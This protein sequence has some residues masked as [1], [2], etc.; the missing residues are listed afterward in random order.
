MSECTGCIY[1][2]LDY[3][4]SEEPCCN[5]RRIATDYYDYYDGIDL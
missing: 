2:K 5:C 4:V 1:D 3:S